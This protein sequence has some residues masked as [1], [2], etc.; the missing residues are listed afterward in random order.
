MTPNR[1][2][3]YFDFSEQVVDAA[4]DSFDDILGFGMM[5][6]IWGMLR[7]TTSSKTDTS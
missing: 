7:C 3:A 5:P 6:F 2:T 4:V 1:W